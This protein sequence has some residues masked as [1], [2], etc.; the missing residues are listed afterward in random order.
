M[1]KLQEGA[2]IVQLIYIQPSEDNCRFIGQ[3]SASDGGMISGDFMSDAKIHKSTANMMK[4]KVYAMGGNLVY[5]QQQFN[6]NEKLTNTL[7]NQTMLGLYI[8]VRDLSWL[9]PLLINNRIADNMDLLTLQTLNLETMM[10]LFFYV[11][12]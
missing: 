6:K 7:T 10:I 3:A 2:E 11:A 9:S 8:N 12:G 1:I 5:I 4:N